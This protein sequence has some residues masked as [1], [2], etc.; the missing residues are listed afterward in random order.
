MP[1]KAQQ[2]NLLIEG[3]RGIHHSF[4]LINQQQILALRKIHGLSIFH[5]DPPFFKAHWAAEAQDDGFSIA[6]QQQ[7]KALTEPH[8]ATAIDCVYRAIF[9]FGGTFLH[10]TLTFMVTEYGPTDNDFAPGCQTPEV[11]TRQD[12]L[13]IT[14]SHWSRLRLIEYGFDETK[15]RVVPHG[16]NSQT[17]YP[18][19]AEDRA[20]N[21]S[22]LGFAPDDIVF[23]NIGAATGNK[24][25]DILL[26]AF[27]LLREKHP[28]L[29]LILKDLRGLYGNTVTQIIEE[30]AERHPV[31]FSDETL[32][33]IQVIPVS[34]SQE[35]LR[36]LYGVA[37]CYVSPYRAEGFNL[38]VL[39]AIACGTQVIVT[40]GGPTDDFCTPEVGFR[41]DSTLHSRD[42]PAGRG[43]Q[44]YFEPRLDAL[45]AAMARFANG[46]A[47]DPHTFAKG[48]QALVDKLSWQRIAQAL[49]ALI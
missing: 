3:W 36:L 42:N 39:E 38:P 23:L 43:V 8:G 31:L 40:E 4:A 7:I 1:H 17:Y 10:K 11:F 6:D 9:P 48:R 41:V 19:T 14:P 35:E 32:A 13:V 37:D 28:N 25:V 44:R 47:L 2:K 21:R 24:G 26:L 15:V 49:H 29:R 30:M 22:D 12:N 20:L 18:L 16:V 46:D 45:V 34:L 33:A 5:T 27:A